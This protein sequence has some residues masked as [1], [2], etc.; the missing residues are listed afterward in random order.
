MIRKYDMYMQEKIPVLVKESEIEY[1]SLVSNQ[2]RIVDLLNHCFHMSERAEEYVYMIAADAKLNVIG[3]FEISHGNIAG[4]ICS[5]RE[6]F[7]RAMISGAATIFITHNH[8]SGDC[9]PS[10]DD[11]TI[12]RN[13]VEA[14]KIIGIPMTDFIIIGDGNFYSFQREGE[15]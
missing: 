14:G 12:C 10:N 11:R 9:T 13:L 5:P 15:I 6:V 7:Q 4:S 2:E 3:V 8:P 1:D